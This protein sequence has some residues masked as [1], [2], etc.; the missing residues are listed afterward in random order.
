MAR[1][2]QSWWPMAG[3]VVRPV[4]GVGGGGGLRPGQGE[5]LSGSPGG[6][7][8]GSPKEQVSPLQ[9]WRP[10]PGGLGRREARVGLH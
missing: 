3:R 5:A 1:A 9:R 6:L 7:A 10:A 8:P 4:G 2:A